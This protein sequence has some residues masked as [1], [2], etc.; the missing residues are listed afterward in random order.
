MKRKNLILSLVCSIVLTI[1]LVAFT[2]VSFI[3]PTNNTANNGPVT[4]V[5]DT[6]TQEKPED[7]ELPIE[8]SIDVNEGRNGSA[9]KP[10]VIVDVETFNKY[11]VEKYLDHNNQYIDYTIV[12]ENGDLVYPDL[13]EGLY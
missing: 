2:V 7:S 6:N 10:Y 12:D 8:P 3:V 11:L 1:G 4:D 5:T 13:N 9:E